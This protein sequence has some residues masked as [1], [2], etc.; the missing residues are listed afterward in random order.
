MVCTANVSSCLALI[1]LVL[2]SRAFFSGLILCYNVLPSLVLFCLAVF[3][4]FL[5]LFHVTISRRAWSCFVVW[6]VFFGV[7]YL[8]S[9]VTLSCCAALCITLSWLV[10]SSRVLSCL[11]SYV[12][13]SCHLVPRFV[14][15]CPVLS[16]CVFFLVLLHVTIACLAPCA[17]PCP[18]GSCVVLPCFVLSYLRIVSRGKI[19]RFKNTFIIIILW[20][21]PCLVALRIVL[22]WLVLSSRV[23]SCFISYVTVS[24]CSALPWL[25]LFSVAVFCLILRYH[26]LSPCA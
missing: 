5:V 17:L 14:L 9:Y 7:F 25:V 2:S 8:L 21:L 22:S 10:L 15:A 23:L 11:I 12:T 4:L 24:L 16:C 13:M 3:F 19:L 1:G 6:C 26:V 20:E 18:A